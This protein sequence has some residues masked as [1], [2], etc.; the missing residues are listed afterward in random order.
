MHLYWDSLMSSNSFP[1]IAFIILAGVLLFLGG[2]SRPNLG[3]DSPARVFHQFSL[4]P[5]A[6]RGS[7]PSSTIGTPF[8]DGSNLGR[9]GY[10]FSLT[11]RNG[12][13]YTC[14]AGHIDLSHVRKCIDWTG[15]LASRIY[16]NLMKN[17]SILSFKMLESSRYHVYIHYPD[18]WFELD[19]KDKDRI[20]FEASVELARHLVFVATTWHEI[21]TWFGYKFTG[22][23]SEFPSAFSWEDTYSNLL[24][25]HIAAYALR[26]RTQ[27]F[28]DAATD[29]I[30][31]ALKTLYVQPADVAR[32]ASEMVRDKWFSGGHFFFVEVI[33]RN[34]DIGFDDG[35][36]EPWIV[37]D[38]KQ[39]PN[40][41]T[42]A[43][44][45][46]SP[47]VLRRYGFKI[48]L[49]IEPREWESAKIL[50]VVYPSAYN[51]P[52]RITPAV[53]FPV[54]IDYMKKNPPTKALLFFGP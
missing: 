25:T 3:P 4:P 1:K 8:S 10:Y 28:D 29:A 7:Y 33:G 15:Y 36:V 43:L 17:E 19:R 9:H 20:A 11:E 40:A 48:E 38:L 47:A 41:E 49:E 13:I 53:H 5:R 51:R 14:R 37:P 16:K 6:R 42:F 50:K 23:Y 39:C 21:L 54:I 34:F 24:G 46:P 26:D 27:K 18:G 2:C 52:R 44:H 31:R 45:V 30:D 12:I 35:L 32:R 22:L